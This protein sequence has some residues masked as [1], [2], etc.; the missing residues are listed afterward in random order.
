MTFKVTKKQLES[1]A[2]K[3]SYVKGGSHLEK[4]LYAQTSKASSSS[5]SHLTQLSRT[6]DFGGRNQSL[7]AN[8][9]DSRDNL[10]DKKNQL[11][12]S[13]SA[14]RSQKLGRIEVRRSSLNAE[15]FNRKYEIIKKKIFGKKLNFV[16]VVVVQSRQVR[17]PAS[18]QV[19]K[20]SSAPNRPF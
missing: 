6:I 18:R 2:I 11:N 9:S 13:L 10:R 17:R 7:S 5:S 3:S 19:R 20:K 14:E 4:S 12:M 16:V 8:L 15:N 1:M